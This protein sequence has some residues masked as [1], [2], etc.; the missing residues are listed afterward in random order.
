MAAAAAAAA[1]VEMAR[2]VVPVAPPTTRM[3]S[4]NSKARM[5][6]RPFSRLQS[7]RLPT[8][9]LQLRSIKPR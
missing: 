6:K 3:M 9:Q 2:A 5:M 8:R 7:L 1:M 4:Q